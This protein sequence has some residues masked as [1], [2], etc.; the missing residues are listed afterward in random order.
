MGA[1]YNVIG[2]DC[3]VNPTDVGL[4]LGAVD[5]LALTIHELVVGTP[6][7]DPATAV[8][9]WLR[10]DPTALL[11]ID[12][13]LGWPALLASGL[14]GHKAGELLPGLANQVFRRETDRFVK[15]L[16]GKQ[17]L[18]VGADRIARTAHAALQLLVEVRR[19]T[20]LS[21]PLAWNWPGRGARVIEVYPAGT[22]KAHGMIFSGYKGNK[23]AAVGRRRDLV[24]M[25]ERKVGWSVATRGL[26]LDDDDALDACVCLL[27]AQDFLLGRAQCPSDRSRAE[28][29]G[30]IW[31]RDINES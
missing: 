16:V 8:A 9:A 31:V 13:P 1:Q 26:A 3:A 28:S 6:R 19:L 24:D 4:A 14:Q 7:R 10:D 29:E 23:P 11:A 17:T 12:S 27:A 18:D 25:L 20:G 15:N 2:I 21:I 5:G 30:W 22:L